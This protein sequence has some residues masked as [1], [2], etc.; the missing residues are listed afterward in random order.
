MIDTFSKKTG[1]LFNKFLTKNKN[2]NNQEVYKKIWLK[3]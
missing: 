1:K 3:F 2:T